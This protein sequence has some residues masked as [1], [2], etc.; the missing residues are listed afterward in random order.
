[1]YKGSFITKDIVKKKYITK[2]PVRKITSVK[3]R[4]VWLTLRSST[5]DII[6]HK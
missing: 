6:F 4:I 1:M 5:I 2:D 3:N